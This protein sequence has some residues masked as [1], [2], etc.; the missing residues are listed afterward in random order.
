MKGFEYIFF[1]KIKELLEIS[2]YKC[3][4]YFRTVHLTSIMKGTCVLSWL[5]S[6]LS[7]IRRNIVFR[8]VKGTWYI[9]R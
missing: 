7:L 9:V 6:K 5:I 3:F 2:L 4:Y 1:S 8:L